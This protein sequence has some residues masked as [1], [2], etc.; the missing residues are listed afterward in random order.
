MSRRVVPV[1][2][3]VRYIKQHMESDPVL[4]GVMIE[5]E[6]SN[7]R[8][9]SS[10]HWYFSLKDERSSIPA[11]MFAAANRKLSFM[12]V[13]GDKVVV[14]G[15]V[16]VY[17]QEGRMQMV[18]MNMQPA[19][20]GDLYLRLEALKKKLSAEGL[21]D[22]AHKKTIP[23]YAVN[24]ALVTGNNTAAREDVLIT[25]NRRWPLCKIHEY[26]CPVQGMDAVPKI[27]DSL[28]K[29]DKGGHQIILLVRGG[30][31]LEDLF[32]FNDESLARCIYSLDTPVICGVGHEI[33]F[34]IADYVSD[35]RANTPTGAAEAAVPD[36]EEVHAHLMHLKKRLV[37]AAV[38][39]DKAS[40][41]MLEKAS[42]SSVFMKP[43]RLY[44]QNMMRLDYLETRLLRFTETPVLKRH[45]LEILQQ[46]FV[47]DMHRSLALMRQ[48]TVLA[49]RKLT[50]Y[51]KASAEAEKLRLKMS[52]ESLYRSVRERREKNRLQLQQE[53]RLLDAYSPL[54]IMDR[55]YSVVYKEEH[56]I[57]GIED[58]SAGDEIS[59]RMRN[60]FFTAEVK[61]RKE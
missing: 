50:E 60:G 57:T 33:D 45:Q 12:P 16:T 44:E 14:T 55:G 26:P 47:L 6:I 59:V 20:I 22:E 37:T 61:E 7:F 15:D 3:L 25:L 58:V 1:S 19:G 13:Q 28:L 46:R 54:K 2:T 42:K 41:I 56:V 39:K 52:E 10:G 23:Q 35:L 43:E 48:E 8:R 27:I 34:T 11:V 36:K 30:G 40:R 4:H 18:I 17:E 32:C 9:P 38:N 51:A 31:S 53:A 49:E 24:I 21:F 29:A 5:G